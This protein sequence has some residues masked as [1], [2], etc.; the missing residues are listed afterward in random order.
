MPPG[1]RTKTAAGA[2]SLGLRIEDVAFSEIG[3]DFVDLLFE[4]D[5]SHGWLPR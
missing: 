3:K 2:R 4:R 1:R 5:L